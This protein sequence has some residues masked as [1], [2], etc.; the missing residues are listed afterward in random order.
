MT[1]AQTLIVHDK[2]CKG[3]LLVPQLSSTLELVGTEHHGTEQPGEFNIMR[4]NRTGGVR[5]PETLNR[6]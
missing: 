5:C 4:R 2:W 1:K 3:P 6:T